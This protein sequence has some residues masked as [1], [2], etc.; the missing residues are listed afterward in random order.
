MGQIDEHWCTLCKK[1]LDKTQDKYIDF[2]LIHQ[3]AAPVIKQWKKPKGLICMECIENDPKL[4]EV[5]DAILKAGN[6]IFIADVCCHSVAVCGTY[7]KSTKPHVNC[8]HISVIGDTV[9][10]KRSHPGKL[11]LMVERSERVRYDQLAMLR[12]FKA[13]L[14]KMPDNLRGSAE[15]FLSREV[16]NIWIPPSAVV[17]SSRPACENPECKKV[18]DCILPIRQTTE[19]KSLVRYI[20]VDCADTLGLKAGDELPSSVVLATR[21]EVI[22][23]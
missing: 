11:K 22:A 20:C 8:R 6:P 12:Q 1:K 4:K 17:S 7:Q 23:R 2:E 19:G 3:G 18:T 21:N 10:C 15:S 16:N 14:K 13:A 9:Y 5:M